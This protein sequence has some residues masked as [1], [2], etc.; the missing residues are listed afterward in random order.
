MQVTCG[1]EH[2]LALNANGSVYSWGYGASGCL[3]HGS[4][5][6]YITPTC[7]DS[8]NGSRITYIECGS[9]HNGAV[10]TTGELWM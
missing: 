10:S 1:A 7:I 6:T 9:Y 3:G 5:N 2:C 4:T 8:L